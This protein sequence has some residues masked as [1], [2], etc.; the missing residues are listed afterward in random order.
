MFMSYADCVIAIAGHKSV[1]KLLQNIQTPIT[2]SVLIA[3]L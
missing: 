1:A 2:T 3:N